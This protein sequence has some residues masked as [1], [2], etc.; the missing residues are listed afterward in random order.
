MKTILA[1]MVG[2]ENAAWPICWSFRTPI[3]DRNG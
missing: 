3:V 2:S 1:M